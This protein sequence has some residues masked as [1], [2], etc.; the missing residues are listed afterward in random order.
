MATPS[1]AASRWE[2]GGGEEGVGIAQPLRP[3]LADG[4]RR[5]INYFGHSYGTLIGEQYAELHGD[6]IRAMA[7][8]ANI[9]HSLGTRDFLVSS[10]ATAEDSFHEF[11]RWCDRSPSC[12]L[13]GRDVTAVGERSAR[14][15]RPGR[16]T[17]SRAAGP[18]PH[19]ERDHPRRL[20]GVLRPGLAKSGH[21]RG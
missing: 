9:D 13:H 19:R 10:A 4:D 11:V 18:G 12:A 14:P 17:R 15:G 2:V 6:R 21:V 1:P 8:T 20:Q 16:D 5:K 3:G 7:L